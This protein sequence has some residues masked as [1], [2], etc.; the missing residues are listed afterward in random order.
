MEKEVKAEEENI[1]TC[2]ECQTP[3]VVIDI[4]TGLCDE[5]LEELQQK[6]S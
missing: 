4:D 1:G 3:N 6:S 5:C 2:N